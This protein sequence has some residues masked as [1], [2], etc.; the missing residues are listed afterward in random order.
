MVPKYFASGGLNRGTDTVPAML[1]PGEFVIR[2]RVVDK[3]GVPFF[4]SLN[5]GYLDSGLRRQVEPLPGINDRAG[6]SV[7]NYS[8]SVNVST[9]NANPNDIARV[10]I[11][12]IKQ[13]DA[14]RIRSN[15]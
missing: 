13:I 12:Q 8:V 7:Y 10:V 2:D 5:K 1:T 6:N 14:Q 11:N 15:R 9:N 3:I 4:D